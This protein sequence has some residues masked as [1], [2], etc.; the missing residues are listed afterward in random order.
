MKHDQG[1][2]KGRSNFDIYYQSWLPDRAPRAA[3]VIAHGLGEHSGR[4]AH[5][6]AALVADG[7]A[8]YAIDHR[9]HGRSQGGSA[10][11]DRWENAVAD[12]DVLVDIAHGEHPKVPL[13]LVGHSMGGALSLGYAAQYQH[14]LSGLALSGPAVA[15][16]GAPPL[17]GTIAKLLSRIAPRLG[18]F[19]IQPE[20]VSRDPEMVQG[21]AHDP[22]NCH[23]KVPVRTLAEIVR[24]VEHLPGVLSRLR[25]PLLIQHGSDDKLAGVAGSRMVAKRVSSQDKTLVVYDGLYHEIFNELPADRAR[26]F[27]DLLNWIDARIPV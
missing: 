25:L 27:T 22:L 19:G 26:V 21:Y 24:L 12:L 3:V 14:K 15:L 18:T 11:V 23:G 16:D 8:V 10:L 2:F 9:G 5:V 20:L 4:Y 13:F 7:A 6:A 1:S 17:L